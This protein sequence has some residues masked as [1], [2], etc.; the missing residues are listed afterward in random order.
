M[1]KA[2]RS[3]RTGCVPT[4]VT[5]CGKG[6]CSA[7]PTFVRPYKVKSGK[8]LGVGR[9]PYCRNQKPRAVGKKPNNKYKKIRREID[10]L[11]SD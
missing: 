6:N 1:V 2:R 8:Y 9:G 11:L 4:V 10:H 7:K 5:D 3:K